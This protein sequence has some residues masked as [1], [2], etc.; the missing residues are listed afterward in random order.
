VV[1]YVHPERGGMSLTK[2]AQTTHV[3]LLGFPMLY[4]LTGVIFAFTSYPLF[5]RCLI[6]PLALA[7]QVGEI[8]CW[9]LSRSNPVFAFGIM[10]LGGVVALTVGAQ[11]ILSLFD[12]YGRGGRLILGVLM[13]ATLGLGGF[14]HMNVIKP[15]LDIE[16]TAPTGYLPT[17]P[18]TDKT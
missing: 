16:K 17:E 1:D 9:W 13:L 3:H 10:G 12:M 8:S 14:L 6:A 2:L 18:S 4:G 15:H 5:L 7:A 11:I